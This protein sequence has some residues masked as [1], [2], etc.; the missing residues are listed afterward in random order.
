VIALPGS[1]PNSSCSS[2]RFHG[3]GCYVEVYY[4]CRELWRAR[5]LQQEFG[6]A[7]S[8]NVFKR[9]LRGGKQAERG[10]GR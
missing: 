8:M 5:F 3:G 2:I 7:A 4:R 10:G 9:R 6:Y 1:F